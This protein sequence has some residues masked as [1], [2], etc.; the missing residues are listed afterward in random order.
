V[1]DAAARLMPPSWAHPLGT[2]ALGRDVL[3]RL[4]HGA[5]ETVGVAALVCLI[6]YVFALVIGFLP[7]FS[8]G[9]ADVAN[10]LPPVIAGILVAAVLG[11]GTVGASVAVALIS[12]PPLAA[13]ASALV[14]ETRSAGFLS[15]QRAIGATE[16]WVLTRHVL[17]SVAGPVARHAVLRLP[18]IA[19]ALASLGVL[20]LGAQAPT[21]EWGLL[22]D[23]SRAYIERAP[24]ATLA[25]AAALA[26]LAGLAVS[27]SALTVS[28]RAFGPSFE[29]EVTA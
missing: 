23:E 1:V 24:W 11:P 19:L 14:Q 10:A 3:A 16:F 27:L 4:G 9:V 2:D 17:P 26:L 25:P 12:W 15:A 6:S 29:K 20:G 8:A 13:H 28:R 21:P 5:R 18:G 7:R 22:L